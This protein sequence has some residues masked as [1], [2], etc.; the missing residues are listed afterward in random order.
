MLDYVVGQIMSQDG[1][2]LIDLA[3]LAETRAVNREDF[4]VVQSTE[5]A[6]GH[7]NVSAAGAGSEGC[8][9]VVGLAVDVNA[10]GTAE[11]PR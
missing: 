1:Q 3:G 5:A 7:L 8:N 9:T 10:D 11:A 4:I 2:T 6:I